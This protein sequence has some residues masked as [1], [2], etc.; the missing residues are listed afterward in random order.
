V[1]LIAN[2]VLMLLQQ[3]PAGPSGE[4][5][6]A[7]DAV[8]TAIRAAYGKVLAGMPDFSARLGVPVDALACT[9]LLMILDVRSGFL[10]AARVG[11]GAILALDPNGD[12]FELV[13]A[14][15]GSQPQ[16]T[17]SLLDGN[18][19]DCLGVRV[20]PNPPQWQTLFLMTDGISHDLLFTDHQDAVR[21]WA[22]GVSTQ[23]RSAENPYVAAEGM[24]NWLATYELPGSWDDRTMVVVTRKED[25]ST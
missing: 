17:Y 1:N 12:V 18:G 13:D 21:T 16:E 11:D 14:P 3:Q 19:R 2:H 10:C 24:V 8:E 6:G 7:M 22:H 25:H 15:E 5:T 4:G 9:L 23:I 20:W